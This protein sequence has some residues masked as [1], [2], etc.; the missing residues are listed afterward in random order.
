MVQQTE[1]STITEQTDQPSLPDA[2][3]APLIPRDFPANGVAS[4]DQPIGTP[5]TASAVVT[6]TPTTETEA[7][8]ETPTEAPSQEAGSQDQPGLS[9]RP[10]D[11][12]EFRAMQSAKDRENAALATELQKYQS[13][14]FGRQIEER[15]EGFK[16]AWRETIEEQGGDPTQATSQI[17]QVSQQIRDGIGATSRVQQ[18]ESQ[19]NQMG[20][21]VGGVYMNAWIQNLAEQHGLD[22]AG[23]QV[24]TNYIDPSR[25]KIDPQTGQLDQG[26][27]EM[28]GALWTLAESLGQTGKAK[29]EVQ[30]ARQERVPAQR[31]ES[32]EGS[33]GMSDNQIV[34]AFADP[35][36]AFDDWT[37]AEAAMRRLGQHPFS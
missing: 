14:E 30:Q 28:G 35:D 32:G 21:A 36:N 3:D 5:E 9:G 7:T 20:Q 2:D 29:T 10:Q 8:P 15:V 37:T 17:E 27:M 4:E 24:L 12:P 18:L 16:R 33:G 31:F 19:L 11:T 34:E 13:N 1:S 23:T 22:E 25:I 6:K 26:V